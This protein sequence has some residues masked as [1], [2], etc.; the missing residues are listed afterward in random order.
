MKLIERVALYDLHW[1]PRHGWS[2]RWAQIG[3]NNPAVPPAGVL[4]GF[5]TCRGMLHQLARLLR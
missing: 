3:Q 5:L 2:C 1:S 4:V